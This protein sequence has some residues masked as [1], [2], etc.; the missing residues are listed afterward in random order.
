MKDL[1]N[2]LIKIWKER[3]NILSGIKNSIFTKEHIEEIAQHRKSICDSC[4]HIDTKGDKCMVPGTG[5]CCGLCGCSLKFK[6]RSLSSSCD[7]KRWEAEINQEEED[8]LY[9][10]INYNPEK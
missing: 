6:L 7:D 4:E 3:N 2:N 9:S 10:S 1:G 8:T 5:P